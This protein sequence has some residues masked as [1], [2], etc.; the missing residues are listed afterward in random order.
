MG[1]VAEGAPAVPRLVGHPGEV[2][3]Q[4][5]VFRPPLRGL[6]QPD[7]G[8][9]ELA[10]LLPEEAEALQVLGRGS[11]PAAQVLE[12]AHRQVFPAVRE[13]GRA[14][15]AA[16]PARRSRPGRAASRPSRRPP[17]ARPFRRGRRGARRG[18]PD[19]P[20]QRQ[21]AGGQ[22][23]ER[24]AELPHRLEQ[25]RALEARLRVRRARTA[26]SPGTPR[27]PWS[28]PSGPSRRSPGRG[29]RGSG[30]RRCSPA[31]GARPRGSASPPPRS[32]P[33][34]PRRTPRKL[35]TAGLVG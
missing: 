28:R 20:G 12:Q 9:D 7:P 11:S 6:L 34:R 24:A 27:G 13:R 21:R 2:E 17:R 29:G 31:P 15:S 25:R 10:R 19:V 16:R 18:R 4:R 32:S 1:E 22:L 23:V 8:L 5:H 30:T 35:W 26:G 33:P 14:G 3:Q